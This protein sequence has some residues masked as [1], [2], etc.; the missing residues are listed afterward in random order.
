M[1]LEIKIVE[2]ISPE[3][4]TGKYYVSAGERWGKHPKIIEGATFDQAVQAATEF[5]K[6]IKVAKED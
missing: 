6:N 3:G 1:D 2:P 5:L 4:P